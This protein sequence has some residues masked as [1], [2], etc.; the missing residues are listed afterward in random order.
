MDSGKYFDLDLLLNQKIDG[1]I[2]AAHCAKD[3]LSIMR[4]LFLPHSSRVPIKVLPITEQ[5]DVSIPYLF[6]EVAASPFILSI[7]HCTIGKEDIYES[8]PWDCEKILRFF[9]FSS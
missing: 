2:K 3:F 9:L 8:V 5:M 7:L 4:A 1:N 6:K